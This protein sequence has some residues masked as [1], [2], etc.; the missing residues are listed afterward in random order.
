MLYNVEAMATDQGLDYDQRATLRERLAYPI[1]CAFEKW[2]VKYYPKALLQG[3]MYKALTY[4][5]S[6]FQRLSR[7]HLDGRYQ[8]DNNLVENDIRP[9]ALGRKNY[10]F[11][12]NHDAAE[13][14]AVM[15]SLL[16]CCKACDVNPR[17]WLTDVLTR[18]PAYNNDYSRDLA[19]LLPHNWKM[20]HSES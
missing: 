7:Y 18:I 13:N 17:E 12:G 2:I 3:R 9:L 5:Y 16:G 4:T 8:I 1:L 19:E 14:A 20:T 6:L 11:C 15:Y 10:L